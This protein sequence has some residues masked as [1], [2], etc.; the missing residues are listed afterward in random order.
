MRVEQ[1]QIFSSMVTDGSV[2]LKTNLHGR[3]GQAHTF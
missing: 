1:H 2:C 3:G